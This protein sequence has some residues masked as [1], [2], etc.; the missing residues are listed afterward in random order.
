MLE[1]GIYFTISVWDPV[2]LLLDWVRFTDF[3][4]KQ[5]KPCLVTASAGA[6]NEV[7]CGGWYVSYKQL[8][9]LGEKTG[10]AKIDPLTVIPLY[11]ENLLPRI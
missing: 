9:C 5:K 8:L 6:R 2:R 3:F 4:K 1:I 11:I 7:G 10:A